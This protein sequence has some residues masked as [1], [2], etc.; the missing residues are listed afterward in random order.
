[1]VNAATMKLFNKLVC[2]PGPNSTTVND[3]L[4]GHRRVHPERGD[5]CDDTEQPDRL[6]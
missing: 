4:E 6:L 3:K 2:K 5:Q 1:M